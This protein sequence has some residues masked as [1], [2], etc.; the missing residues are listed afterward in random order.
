MTREGRDI[1]RCEKSEKKDEA[2]VGNTKV[3]NAGEGGVGDHKLECG[4]VALGGFDASSLNHVRD[5]T[6]AGYCP[7]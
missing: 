4:F 3:G 7:P 6:P 5:V 1:V 2:E